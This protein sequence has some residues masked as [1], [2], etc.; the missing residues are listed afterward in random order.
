MSSVPAPAF[1]SVPASARGLI[2]AAVTI[3]VGAVAAAQ[4]QEGWTVG[5]GLLFAVMLALCT[6]GGL[7]EVAGPGR[8]A[9]QPHLPVFVAGAAVLS[10]VAIAALAVASF[11][12]GG[13]RRRDRWYLTAFNVGTW[14]S[15]GIA[16]HMVIRLGGPGTADDALAVTALFGGALVFVALNH[17]LVAAVAPLSRGAGPLKALRS[18]L[19]L[20]ETGPT[21]AVVDVA[22][23]LTGVSLAALWNTYPA[24]LALAAGPAGLVCASLWV[25]ILRHKSRTDPKTGLFNFEHAQK[26]I[27]DALANGRRSGRPVSILMLDLDH[28]RQI[29][30]RF[31]H[32]AGDDLINAVGGVLARACAGRGSAARFGGEEFCA[33]LPDVPMEAATEIAEQIRRDVERL[34]LPSIS[35]GTPTSTVSIGIAAAPSHGTKTA[36]VLHAADMALY[37]AKLGGRNRVRVAPPA[38][39]SEAP[40]PPRAAV[41]DDAELPESPVERPVASDD[42]SEA[43]PAAG[44]RFIA[45]Y[46]T[47]LA[48]GALA[49]AVLSDFGRIADQPWLFVALLTC[50][51]VLDAVRLDLFERLQTSPAALVV[52]AL[53]AFFGPIGPIAGEALILGTRL[54]RRTP[55]IPALFDFGALSLAGAAAAATFSAL[56]MSGANIIAEGALAG[57]AYYVV[58]MP[59]LALVITFSRGGNPI[60]NFREQLAWLLPHY[61]AFGVLGGA[62]LLVHER[63]GWNAFLVFGVPT[64]VLWVAEK[65]YLERSRAG[66][67]ELRRNHAELQ[68][69][70][71]NLRRLLADNQ[72]LLSRLQH[73]YLSTI[74]SLARTIEAKDPY[75]G[76]HTDRVSRLTSVIAT[77]L[78]FTAD[79]LQAVEVGA[80]VHDIGKIGVQDAVLLKPG[81]LTPEER[82]EIERHPEIGSYI[83]GEL[84]V[85]AIVKQMVRNHHERYDGRGYP[86]GLV[87]DEIPLAARILTVSDTL[88][89]MTSDRPYRKAL[90]MVTA[91]EEIKNGAGTQFCPLVVA[92]LERCLLRDARIVED[93]DAV[94]AAPVTSA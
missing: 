14:L 16:A 39:G 54:A 45:P 29:N 21:G 90:P 79:E 58:N 72:A 26:L 86:D 22:L 77:E 9:L 80:V 89:A 34:R 65:Q 66:V 38:A 24:A 7:F 28:L 60:A 19:T 43:R 82:A 84:D 30:N 81:K 76:G 36:A 88:D 6:A 93:D 44:R 56:P 74:T 50:M 55:K 4:T 85:P 47:L 64:I 57:I 41:V 67:E 10:P 78:G 83:L 94:V 12:P 40:A 25:P 23:A 37:D 8:Y 2:V 59:L 11:V 3:A 63:M 31:G 68:A 87:G 53:A 32:L 42:A 73:S 62:F 1:R 52:L 69:A 92:A 35:D 61:A 27:D 70:N 13:I 15:A 91:I 18:A 5:V 75:T 46:A 71:A 20:G 33:V 17:A 51:V 49:T 48:V